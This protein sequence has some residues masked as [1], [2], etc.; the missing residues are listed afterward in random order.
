MRSPTWSASRKGAAPASATSG[1]SGSGRGGLLCRA[2]AIVEPRLALT[3]LR[4]HLSRGPG[5]Q[6]LPGREVIGVKPGRV[7]D[8]AGTWHHGDLVVL[9]TG[10]SLTGVA[11]PHLHASGALA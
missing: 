10:A 2:D 11:G 5:Y 7:L 8:H 4:A 3:A 6:W 9:C 1:S